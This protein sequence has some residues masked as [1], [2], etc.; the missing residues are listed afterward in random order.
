MKIRNGFVSNS[1]SSSFVVALPKDYSLSDEEMAEIREM[2]ED[3]DEYFS[4]YE[5]MA[6]ARGEIEMIDERE[7]IQMMLEGKAIPEDV[8]PVTDDVKN[9]D[10]KKGFEFLTTTGYFWADEIDGDVP[11]LYAAKA[12]VEVLYNE[13]IID[14]L[15]TNSSAGQ[16]VN[17]LADGYINS[18]GMKKVKEFLEK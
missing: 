18:K 6:E 8:E 12:I 1:S 9:K 16:I 5:D 13:I 10:I 15:E 14:S 4:Y 17:I 3:F 7:K 11:V 2:M